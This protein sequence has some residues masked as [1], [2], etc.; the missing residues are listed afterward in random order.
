MSNHAINAIKLA[1][2]VKRFRKA[3]DEL[4]RENR[5][6]TERLVKYQ[7]GAKYQ[8]EMITALQAE[9]VTANKRG[10][11]YAAVIIRMHGVIEDDCPNTCDCSHC[12]GN[13]CG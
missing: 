3:F 7:E 11:E 9:L 2:E 12:C 8:A 13:Y 6:L 5:K 10:D 1:A 4:Q